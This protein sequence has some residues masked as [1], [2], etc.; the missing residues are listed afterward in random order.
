MTVIQPKDLATQFAGVLSEQVQPT[1]D[2]AKQEV[3]KVVADSKSRLEAEV[4]AARTRLS[5]IIEKTRTDFL[6]SMDKVREDLVR[7]TRA[8]AWMLILTVFSLV[9]GGLALSLWAGTREVN[10]QVAALQGSI[11]SAQS[12]IRDASRELDASR[13]EIARMKEEL[14]QAL[15]QAREARTR[16]ERAAPSR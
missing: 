15:V 6:A 14:A 4:V 16:F 3:D 9:G 8:K 5:E 13:T 1:L 11:I 12:Q 10:S 2:N 7:D